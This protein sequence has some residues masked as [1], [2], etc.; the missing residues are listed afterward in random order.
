MNDGIQIKKMY[1][2]RSLPLLENALTSKFVIN[3]TKRIGKKTSK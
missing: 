2:N 1:R 3:Q